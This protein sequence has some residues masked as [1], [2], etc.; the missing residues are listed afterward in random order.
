MTP[1]NKAIVLWRVG[2][3]LKCLISCLFEKVLR[4]CYS[5]ATTISVNGDEVCVKKFLTTYLNLLKK[6]RR[7]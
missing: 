6:W 2:S 5:I 1:F 3:T 7:Y 4:A